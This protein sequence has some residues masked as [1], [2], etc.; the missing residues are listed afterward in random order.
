SELT[1]LCVISSHRDTV[2]KDVPTCEESGLP[3]FPIVSP[4][5]ISAPSAIEPA[6]LE[7]I[8]GWIADAR[9]DVD[10]ALGKA[11]LNATYLD[12]AASAKQVESLRADVQQINAAIK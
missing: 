8:A 2:A 1:A 12:A 5:M 7:K 3:S 6:R 4:I 11:G 9:A 10:A